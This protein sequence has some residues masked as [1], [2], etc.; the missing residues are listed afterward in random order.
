MID[1]YN[2]DCLEVMDRLI[3]DG[4]KV[5][6]II[7]DPPYGTTSCKWDSIIPIDK[8]WLRLKK[9]IKKG[10][11]IVLFGNEPYTSTLRISNIKDYKYDFVWKKTTPTGH[12]NAKKRPMKDTENIAVF[13]VHYSLYNPQ[14]SM[15]KPYHKHNSGKIIDDANG[16]YIVMVDMDSRSNGERYPT[17]TLAFKKDGNKGSLH[18]TQKPLALMEYL[19]KTYTN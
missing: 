12:L 14:M 9:L 3:A 8:M 5:D 7:T 15:G 17:T 1:L 19:V 2:G 10:R 6:A 11:A 16:I 13:N 4:V 18:P